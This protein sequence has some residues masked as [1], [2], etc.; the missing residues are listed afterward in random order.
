M[1]EE[2]TIFFS[3][4]ILVAQLVKNPLAIWETWV[5]SLG[6][7]DSLERGMATHSRI[8][9]TIEAMG[10]KRVG[11]DRVT[12]KLYTDYILMFSKKK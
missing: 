7:E 3:L 10:S 12:S 8:P 4:P 6:W 9:W 2:I 1:F 5:Q 11:H